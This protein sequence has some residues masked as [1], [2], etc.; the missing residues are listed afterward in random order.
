MA[1][2]TPAR[3]AGPLHPEAANF[4]VCGPVR[5]NKNDAAVNIAA[6]PFVS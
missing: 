3:R 6:A 2:P 4:F 1:T 5:I